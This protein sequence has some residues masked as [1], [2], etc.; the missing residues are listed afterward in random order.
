MSAT[1]SRSLAHVAVSAT[2]A[3][4]GVL[5]LYDRQDAGGWASIQVVADTYGHLE[6]QA[7]HE[8]IL[9]KASAIATLLSDTPL[10]HRTNGESRKNKENRKKPRKPSVPMVGTTGIEPVTPTMSR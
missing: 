8:T 9:A 10:T 4:N 6:K 2:S 3:R 1:A 5:R 7:V